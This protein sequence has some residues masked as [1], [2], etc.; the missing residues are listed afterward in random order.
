VA[1]VDCPACGE[2]AEPL[3]DQGTP[4]VTYGADGNV[5]AILEGV[6]SLHCPRCGAEISERGADMASRDA[7]RGSGAGQEGEPEGSI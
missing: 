1:L 2:F 5:A 6:I 7:S 3:I 4:L